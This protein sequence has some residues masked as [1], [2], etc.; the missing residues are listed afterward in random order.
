MIRLI[1]KNLWARRRRNI[2]LFGELILVSILTW[3]MVDPI[4][5]MTYNR[6]LPL[7][8]DT[9]G[10]Y[11]LNLGTIPLQ[12]ADDDEEEDDSI[13]RMNN[14]FRILDDVRRYEGVQ[15]ATPVVSF[16]YPNSPG[17]YGN[18]LKYDSLSVGV[19]GMF[20][21]PHTCF[22]ETYGIKGLGG[23]TA[24]QLD[25]RDYEQNDIICTQNMSDQF[26]PGMELTGK[27]LYSSYISDTIPYRVVGVVDNIRYRSFEQP[28]PVFFKVM[29]AD[30]DDNDPADSKIVF[31]LQEGISESRFLHEFRSYM[32]THLKFGNLFVR[33]VV[34]YDDHIK[35]M[36]YGYGVTNTYRMNTVLCLFFLINLVLG[37]TGTFWLQTRSR[38]EEVGVMLSYGANP[39]HIIRMLL[40]EG[41]VLATIAVVIG[42]FIYLQYGLSEGLYTMGEPFGIYWINDFTY[43]IVAVSEIVYIVIVAVVLLGVYIPARKISRILPTEALRDE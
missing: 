4:V 34:S 25:E 28:L 37:V 17:T 11:M 23:H 10:L 40:G 22:F 26:F 12:S 41:A 18:T 1:L 31:R 38:C 19:R 14:L 7:G 20:F 16:S 3:I 9:N 32:T 29:D 30:D 21:L 6:N 39:S 2:W 5:V 27:K 36:E 43:H 8:Y 35:D 15:S 33:S 24:R 13:H 42:C